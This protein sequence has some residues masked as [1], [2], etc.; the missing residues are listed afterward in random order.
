M[1]PC[2]LIDAI[3]KERPPTAC[4]SHPIMQA[5]IAREYRRDIAATS[6]NPEWQVEPVIVGAEVYCDWRDFVPQEIRE[7]WPTLDMDAKLSL[8]LMAEIAL[9]GELKRLRAIE[10][11]SREAFDCNDPLDL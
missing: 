7:V 2:Q 9:T 3:A 11:L 6:F 8:R 5:E 4:S 10:A 1:N